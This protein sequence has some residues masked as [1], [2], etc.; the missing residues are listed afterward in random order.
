MSANG[1]TAPRAGNRR[2]RTVVVVAVVIIAAN[3]V[4]QGLD[5]AV[6]GNEPGGAA[7]SSYATAPEGLAGL[8]TLLVQYGHDVE[9]QRSAIAH[10]ALP[11]DATAFV[12]EPT[13]L[14]TDDDSA[15]LQFVTNGGHLVVG[16]AS[17]FYLHNLSDEPPA[18]QASGTTSWT[19]IDASLGSVREVAAAGVGSWSESGRGQ[20]LV[21]A[22]NPALLTRDTV[23][24][25]E[26]DFLADPSPLENGYLSQADNAAF[27]LALSGGTGRPVVFPEGT[28]GYGASRGLSA[29]PG[30]WKI[31]LIL[32]GVAA[33]AF[34]WS[35]ARRFGP[36]DR[37]ARD[38]PP[39]RAAYVDALSVSLERAGDRAGAL[40]PAQRWARS[41]VASR[42]GL[43]PDADELEL[44]AAARSFGCSEQE[45]GALL[46]PVVDDASTLALGRA[47]ARVGAGAGAERTQ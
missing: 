42:A 21:G 29:L 8:S 38:L 47:V 41:R 33:L 7:G 34:V 17:P 2:V 3:L 14:T 4:A 24:R 44:A 11:A 46:A 5:H 15:L 9:Q 20:P 35:R 32:I 1:T 26:I 18:W 25:G 30:R 39:A 36:P 12:L 16:G 37:T 31:A 22:N 19:R 6:G 40:A 45:I 23:G 28:H 27:A 13:E 10:H 43:G